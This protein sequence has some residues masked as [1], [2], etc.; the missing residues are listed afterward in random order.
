[1]ARLALSERKE[2]PRCGDGSGFSSRRWRWSK[3][4]GEHSP[5][6]RT[7]DLQGGGPEAGAGDRA[8]QLPLEP[9]ARDAEPRELGQHFDEIGPADELDLVAHRPPR[10]ES[11]VLLA[12]VEAYAQPILRP[13]EWLERATRVADGILDIDVAG[14]GGAVQARIVQ[15]R[16]AH[17]QFTV[18]CDAARVGEA[19]RDQILTHGVPL[20]VAVRLPGRDAQRLE[21]RGLRVRAQQLVRAP[22]RI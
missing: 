10:R 15:E 8:P 17:Q 13:S 19:L 12:G 22:A 6:V 7:S 21:R 20:H 9:G 5:P 11:V 14:A 2:P 18:E 3:H 4:A 16:R 1:M